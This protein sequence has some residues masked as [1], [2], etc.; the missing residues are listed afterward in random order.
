[1]VNYVHISIY[2]EARLSRIANA[3]F[4]HHGQEACPT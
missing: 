2:P 1:M 4:A 3:I